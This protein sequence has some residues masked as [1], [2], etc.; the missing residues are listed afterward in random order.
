[1]SYPLHRIDAVLVYSG[2]AGE[3]TCTGDS[4]GPGLMALPDQAEAVVSV[5]SDGPD[6]QLS[7]DGWDDRVDL[8]TDWIVQ[9]VS[10]WDAPPIFVAAATGASGSGND[11]GT[12][13]RARRGRRRRG[14]AAS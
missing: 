5:V 3:Q 8:I 1:V 7:Q 2:A 11:S 13:P 12:A 6:C 4:G 9:T 14:C 10:A